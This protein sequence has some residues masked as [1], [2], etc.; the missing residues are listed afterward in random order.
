LG[1]AIVGILAL[2][3]VTLPDWL[4]AA[5]NPL[6]DE[7]RPSDEGAP[8]EGADSRRPTKRVVRRAPAAQGPSQREGTQEISRAAARPRTKTA[9]LDGIALSFE[10]AALDAAEEDGRGSPEGLLAGFR[11]V[12]STKEPLSYRQT[13]VPAGKYDVRAEFEE[14]EDGE[15]KFF[16]RFSKRETVSRSRKS[17]PAE[18]GTRREAE[19]EADAPAPAGGNGSGGAAAALPAAPAKALLR[20]PLR[21]RDAKKP[22][23]RIEVELHAQEHA[24]DDGSRLQIVVRS[25]SI[26]G[27][28]TLRR[29]VEDESSGAEAPALDPGRTDDM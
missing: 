25:G 21:M 12:F 19:E 27:S 26:E 22:S 8:V 28:A 18:S 10:A 24:Q 1:L 14:D 20:L 6:E 13:T 17:A 9:K 29:R 15:K 23:T 16:L 2:R 5:E 11:G 4:S 7:R 3:F